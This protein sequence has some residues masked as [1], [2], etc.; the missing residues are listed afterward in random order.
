MFRSNFKL[1]SDSFGGESGVLTVENVT[2]NFNFDGLYWSVS[3]GVEVGATAP[4]TVTNWKFT[5]PTFGPGDKESVRLDSGSTKGSFLSDYAPIKLKIGLL[6][7]IEFEESSFERLLN[8]GEVF[9]DVLYLFTPNPGFFGGNEI[10]ATGFEELDTDEPPSGV[11]VITQFQLQ[12]DDTIS[13]KFLKSIL[14]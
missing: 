8:I 6:F 4:V 13:S 12:T 2:P 11:P 7:K 1:V 3:V 5:T 14:L 9:V 10:T